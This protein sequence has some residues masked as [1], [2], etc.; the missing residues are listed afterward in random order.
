[1]SAAL[2]LVVSGSCPGAPFVSFL[3]LV[4]CGVRLFLEPESFCRGFAVGVHPFDVPASLRL[5]VSAFL[6]L[7]LFS[8]SPWRCPPL[9]PCLPSFV[10][11]HYSPVILSAFLLPDLPPILTFPS[12][13]SQEFVSSHCLHF[14]CYKPKSHCLRL[15]QSF[16][17]L[18]PFLSC[19]CG[20]FTWQLSSSSFSCVPP[21][22]GLH[23]LP[24]WSR[25]SNSGPNLDAIPCYS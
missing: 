15:A 7:S 17:H 3:S 25:W 19:A 22:T 10:S 12:F 16:F 18:S 5:V 2:R 20:S 8:C 11:L 24:A 21:P 14:T 23:S 4:S 1:M 13:V 6:T 9:G